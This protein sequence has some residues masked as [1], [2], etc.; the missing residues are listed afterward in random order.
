MRP[1]VGYPGARALF[2]LLVGT[3]CVTRFWDLGS[4]SLWHDEAW[5][6]LS[7]VEPGVLDMLL[8]F[9]YPQT[10]PPLFL[11]LVRSLVGLFGGSEIALRLLPAAAGVLSGVLLC[12]LARRWSGSEIVALLAMS[13]WLAN[14]HVLR[15][16]RE[17]KQYS[18]DAL[19]TVLLLL[20]ADSFFREADPSKR[21]RRRW[22]L[23]GATLACLPL[24]YTAALVVPAVALGWVLTRREPL[25]LTLYVGSSAGF[26]LVLHRIFVRSQYTDWLFDFWK[27]A[28]LQERTISGFV[29]FASG[30]SFWVFRFLF[31]PLDHPLFLATSLTAVVLF[32]AG[33][34]V[35]AIRRG[36]ATPA[37][38][39]APIAVTL[40]AAC[41]SR[42]PYG[43]IRAD[44]FFMP[45]VMI[46]VAAGIA[47]LFGAI[48]KRQKGAAWGLTIASVLLFHA[49]YLMPLPRDDRDIRAGVRDLEAALLPGDTVAVSDP[50]LYAFRYYTRESGPS[51]HRFSG[52]NSAPFERAREELDRILDEEIGSGRV[53]LLF[54][55]DRG[56]RERLVAHAAGRCEI[57]SRTAY[58]GAA[59]LRMECPAPGGGG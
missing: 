42:Y 27:E 30:R 55:R 34:V 10:S 40:G 3:A 11:I 41:F 37:I 19:V 5:V 22:L 4:Y 8:R 53:W 54:E 50:A 21:A 7:I 14:P 57:A 52:W 56:L 1:T 17:L 13:I 35:L 39:L 36:L 59:L 16:H 15:Y 18:T 26:F 38:L 29:E 25:H 28:F 48:E 46:G 2:W 12:R 20:L 47:S 44:L 33:V 45:L 43:G 9:E 24:S 31:G 23:L 49:A 58:E 51:V 6:A 32:L